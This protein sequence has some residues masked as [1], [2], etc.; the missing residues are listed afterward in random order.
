MLGPGSVEPADDL[1]VFAALAAD[2][3]DGTAGQV[4]RLPWRDRVLL[5]VG[6]G[7]ATPRDLRTAGAALARAVKGAEQLATSVAEVAD[8]AGLRAFVEGLVLASFEFTMRSTGPTARP[9]ERVVLLGT[10]RADALARG[11]AVAGAGWRARFLATVPSN[12]KNPQW[13]VEQATEIA[14]A[15]GLGVD[16][17]DEQ[18]LERRGYG[19]ISAVGRASATPP[20]L[21]TLRYRPS[22]RGS[23]KA[24]HLVLAGKGITFDSGG[25]SIKGAE[26]MVNMKRDMSGA[27]VVLSVMAALAEVGCPLRVTAL[28]P[29]AENVI[30]GDALRPGDV[31]T[32]YGG[33]TTEVT[34]T[35]AEGRLVLADALAHAVADLEPDLLVDVATLTGAMKVAMGLR[36]GGYFAT[37]DGLA[38]HLDAAA[39]AA[40]E[41]LWRMPLADVYAERLSSKVAD[42]DNAPGS[43]QAITAALFLQHFTGGLPWAHLD[44]AS[45]GDALEDREEWTKG[46]TG[47]G[48]RALLYWLEQAEPL[49]GVG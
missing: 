27:A 29:L 24:P 8:D 41:P 11:L 49:A 1:D 48:A 23:R 15:A 44:L 2:D 10:E 32:H 5:L 7:E 26:L 25:L 43:A 28:L 39:A 19:G 35:D 22:G 37:D 20:R 42:A 4:T 17:L 47:F 3:A 21:L 30:G 31:I 40:G 45:V 18:Q 13:F 33:R 34:N 14:E 16:V 12:L 38:G 9:V 46:P 36:I 6:V